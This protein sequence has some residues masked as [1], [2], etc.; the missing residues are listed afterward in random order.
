MLIVPGCQNHITISEWPN[1]F[2]LGSQ[3]CLLLVCLLIMLIICEFKVR[4]DQ[5][6]HVSF[7][8]RGSLMVTKS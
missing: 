8:D 5:G 4:V 7:L 6:L 1:P 2:C 3:G